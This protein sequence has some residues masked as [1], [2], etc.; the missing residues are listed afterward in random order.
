VNAAR[1]V[2]RLSGLM[3]LLELYRKHDAAN[4]QTLYRLERRLIRIRA[5]L[6]KLTSDGETGK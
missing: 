4:D 6:Q 1:L 3:R 2:E 5:A